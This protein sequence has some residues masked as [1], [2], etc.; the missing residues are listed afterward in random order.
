MWTWQKG[1]QE[2]GY[3]KFT[4]ISFWFFDAHLIYYPTGSHIPPHVDQVP[5]GKHYRVNIVLRPAKEGGEFVCNEVFIN[6]SWLKFFRPDL[7]E[8]SVSV[9]NKGTRLIFSFGWVTP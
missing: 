4:L 8:H 7:H 6:W 3:D 1:R 9:I 2:T 5:S